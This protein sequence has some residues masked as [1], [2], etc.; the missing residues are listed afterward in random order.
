MPEEEY[1]TLNTM[2]C[3]QDDNELKIT[4]TRENL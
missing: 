1:K 3:H 2:C 4:K